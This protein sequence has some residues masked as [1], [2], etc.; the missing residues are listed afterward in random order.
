M[1][2]YTITKVDNIN[3]VSD[4]DNT[5]SFRVVQTTESYL[6]DGDYWCEYEELQNILADIRLSDALTTSTKNKKG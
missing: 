5:K 4:I 3:V 2:T 1:S 6:I